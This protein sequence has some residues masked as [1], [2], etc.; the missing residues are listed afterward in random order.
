MLKLA[1]RLVSLTLAVLGASLFL[2][3][4]LIVIAL[5]VAAIALGVSTLLVGWHGPASSSGDTAG[6]TEDRTG[7]VGVRRG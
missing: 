3:D 7:S 6:T 1:V 4:E 5:I 2:P